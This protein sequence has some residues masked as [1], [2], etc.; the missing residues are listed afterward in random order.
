MEKGI[1]LQGAGQVSWFYSQGNTGI[2]FL[3]YY[4]VTQC[5]VQMYWQDLLKKIEDGVFDPTFI[6]THRFKIDEMKE[7][8]NSFDKKEYGIM[9]VSVFL[10]PSLLVWRFFRAD[11]DRA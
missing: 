8:Y 1:T 11:L 3:T 4:Y 7:L 2:G 9:K 6:L 5:P 10:A